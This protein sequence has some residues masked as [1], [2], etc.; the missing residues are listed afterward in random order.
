[1]FFL[2]FIGN[3]NYKEKP[4]WAIIFIHAFIVLGLSGKA[5]PQGNIILLYSTETKL[6]TILVSKSAEVQLN[7]DSKT[8]LYDVAIINVASGKKML[9][10]DD[11]KP[12]ASLNLAFSK[13]GTYVAC[14]SE[15]SVKDLK[16][17]TC[18]QINVVGLLSI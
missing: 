2:K 5:E 13:T 4:I 6:K 11:L 7:N 16:K 1:M 14:Y 17:N 12:S 10:I 3:N 8:I 15:E 9:S 18:L